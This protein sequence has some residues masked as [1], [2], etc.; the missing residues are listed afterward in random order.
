MNLGERSIARGVTRQLAEP[1]PRLPA[2]LR[3]QGERIAELAGVGST[4]AERFVTAAR[5][6]ASNRT[7]E[8]Y[9]WQSVADQ[10]KGPVLSEEQNKQSGA[11]GQGSPLF[12]PIDFDGEDIVA[13]EA[14]FGHE[15]S[16]IYFLT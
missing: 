4:G 11:P 3:H 9:Y 1:L 15:N 14:M 6:R 5:K 8:R 7:T 10:A 2:T 13:K 12:S 16:R